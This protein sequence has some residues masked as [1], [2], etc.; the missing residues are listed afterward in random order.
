MK[1]V[2]FILFSIYSYTLLST[3][4]ENDNS[5]VI[6]ISELNDALESN[7]D[8]TDENL[9]TICYDNPLD[10]ELICKTCHKK[11]ACRSC[12]KS[13]VQSQPTVVRCPH[14]RGKNDTLLRKKKI[15]SNPRNKSPVIIF[16]SDCI[17]ITGIV[18]VY[19]A[20]VYSWY[21][22]FTNAFRPEK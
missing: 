22:V 1:P 7:S 11:M 16:F 20:F 10:P 17:K 19:G 2:L 18:G 14:C 21:F 13:I 3:E 8:L 6:E 4:V 9:C 5:V 15:L 12:M